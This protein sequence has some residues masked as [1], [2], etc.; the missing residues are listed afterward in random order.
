[1]APTKIVEG[2][3][4]AVGFLPAGMCR[5]VVA[6]FGVVTVV[7]QVNPCSTCMKLTFRGGEAPIAWGTV[8]NQLDECKGLN[9]RTYG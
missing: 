7:R 8:P 6:L 9:H 3:C 4:S 2:H 5:R 1:M